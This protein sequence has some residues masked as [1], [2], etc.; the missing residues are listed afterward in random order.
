MISQSQCRVRGSFTR[1]PVSPFSRHR[2]KSKQHKE[3]G[4]TKKARPVLYP[5]PADLRE[6]LARDVTLLLQRLLST[7]THAHFLDARG[8]VTLGQHN[9]PLS[10][11]TLRINYHRPSATIKRTNQRS[12]FLAPL[13][14]LSSS[15]PKGANAASVNVHVLFSVSP[16]SRCLKTS[17]KLF[18]KIRRRTV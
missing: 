17:T 11:H 2:H 10:T 6:P 14:R 4:K 1:R 9:A 5:R 3:K 16:G 18:P 8:E 12:E 13:S 15:Y 7:K